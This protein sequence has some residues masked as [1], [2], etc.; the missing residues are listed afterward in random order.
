MASLA[1]DRGYNASANRALIG[2]G[3][4]IRACLPKSQPPENFVVYLEI[5]PDGSL[6]RSRFEPLTEE[7]K[8]FRELASKR[9]FPTPPGTYVAKHNMVFNRRS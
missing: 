3:S 8:C 6:G 1:R 2:D 4:E 9:R 7:G 5:P